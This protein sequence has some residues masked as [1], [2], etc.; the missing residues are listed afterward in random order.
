M[1][2]NFYEKYSNFS[3]LEKYLVPNNFRIVGINMINNNLFSR[4][5][6]FGGVVYFNKNKF[7]L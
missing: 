6:F 1:L 2:D 7:E 3:D 4:L 5:T